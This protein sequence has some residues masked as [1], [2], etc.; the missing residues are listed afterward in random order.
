MTP[1][2]NPELLE[3][4]TP[5]QAQNIILSTGVLENAIVTYIPFPSH[6]VIP[7]LK[8]T[9]CIISNLDLEFNKVDEFE[10]DNV[11]FGGIF[12]PDGIK[13]CK[14]TDCTIDF[15]LIK[16]S[17]Q[18]AWVQKAERDYQTGLLLLLTSCHRNV[19]YAKGI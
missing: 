18:Q 7:S 9:N 3:V 4:I 17:T 2:F 12:A 6:S 1:T 5:E 13:K 15:I 10:A 16:N 14:I 11:Y 8:L 19:N